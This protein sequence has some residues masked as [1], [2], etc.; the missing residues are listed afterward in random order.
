MYDCDFNME[1]E[2]RDNEPDDFETYNQNEVDD[3]RN[4]DCDDPS[5]GD[6]TADQ[7][8]YEPEPYY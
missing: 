2:G 5:E 6:D 3:Y 8:E 4:E 7:Q 1:T